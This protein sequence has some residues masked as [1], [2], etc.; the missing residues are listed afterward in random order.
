MEIVLVIIG[1]IAGGGITF[2]VL[3][4]VSGGSIKKKISEAEAEAE[5]IK[6]EKMLQAKEN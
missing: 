1:L 6:K 2:G 5:R 4:V 3:Q